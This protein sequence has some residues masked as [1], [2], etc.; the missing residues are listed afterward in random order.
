MSSD[1]ADTYPSHV[2]VEGTLLRF[3][4][5]FTGTTTTAAALYYKRQAALSV[6]TLTPTS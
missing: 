6:T 4:P 1:F 3:A 2:A 5:T